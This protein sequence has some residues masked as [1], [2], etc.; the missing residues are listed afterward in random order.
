MTVDA[1]VL[2]QIDAA[3][4]TREDDY[5]CMVLGIHADSWYDIKT[6]FLGLDP[7]MSVEDQCLILARMLVEA[8]FLEGDE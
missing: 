3:L 8:R 5:A 1:D 4:D 7:E 2:A 6:R